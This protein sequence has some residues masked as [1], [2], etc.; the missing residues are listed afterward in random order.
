MQEPVPLHPGH[1]TG[2]EVHPRPVP[3]LGHPVHRSGGQR[4]HR[5]QGQ[6]E[7][8]TDQRSGERVVSGGPVGKCPHGVRPEAAGGQVH[9][10]LSYLRLPE[11]PGR[12]EPHHPRPGGGGGGAADFPVVAGGARAAEHR[13]AAEPAGHPQPHPLQG[14]AGL[15]LQPPHQERLWAVEQGD[16]WQNPDQRDVH[17][18]NDPGA[19][20]EGQLQVQGYH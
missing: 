3:H 2:R 6:Q 20:A 18:R 19:A 10:R 17:R 9:R 4:R 11:G 12:Q 16:R 14:G 13:L 5:G 7:S 15:E 1:G 8:P